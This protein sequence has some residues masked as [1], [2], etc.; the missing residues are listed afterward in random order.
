MS[1]GFPAVQT[2]QR[3]R[4]RLALSDAWRSFPD[5]PREVLMEEPSMQQ[6]IDA[7][8]A[9]AAKGLTGVPDALAYELLKRVVVQINGSEV[10]DHDWIER[11]S[12]LSRQILQVLLTRVMYPKKDGQESI[13]DLLKKVRVEV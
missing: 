5:D 10:T 1:T 12:P 9:V 11:T 2:L 13:D 6:E 3:A 4:H 8:K 7:A